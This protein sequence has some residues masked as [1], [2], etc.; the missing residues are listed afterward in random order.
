MPEVRS[1]SFDGTGSFTGAFSIPTLS[2]S[3][4][5]EQTAMTV[6]AV[7]QAVHIYANTIGALDL[8]VAER[9]KRGGSRPAFEHP[10]YDLVHTRPNRITTSFRFRQSLIAHALTH[11]N[12]Y[13]EIERLGNQP[14]ALHLIDPR[15]V[16][17]TILED[18]RLVYHLVKEGKDVAARDMVHIAGLGW[19]GIKGYSAITF[20]REAIG[21]AIAQQAWE[22]ALYG[23]SAVP[24][25]YLKY[26]GTLKQDTKDRLR[27]NWNKEHQGAD[28]SNKIAVFDAGL[29][30]VATSFSPEDAQLILSRGFSI[31]EI[32][33]LFNLPQHMLGQMEHSTFGNIE[34]QNIQFY[35]LS[36]MPWL[37]NIEQELNLKLFSA[38]ERKQFFVR[39][40]INSLLRGNIAAQ[41]ARERRHV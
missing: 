28:R 39:H 40:D 21:V 34:E 13:A 7:W 4:V 11:G 29:E 30:W 18:G 24:N 17:P 32:A 38:A 23:N 26:P 3:T 5:N 6:T 35:Q 36:L 9:D 37:V 33:R 1:T 12:G 22:G 31:A 8:Y 41:T 14:V 10:T 16:R 25:G 27:D 20:G 15:N 2:G 19:D